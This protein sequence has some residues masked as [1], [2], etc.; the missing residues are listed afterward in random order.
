MR[1]AAKRRK[2]TLLAL[3]ADC[4]A[5]NSS[6]SALAGSDVAP[7]LTA[8]LE[9]L[10][11][12]IYQMP[13]SVRAARRL[14]LALAA[15]DSLLEAMKHVPGANSSNLRALPI[16]VGPQAS[17]HLTNVAAWPRT[18]PSRS[19][20]CHTTPSLIQNRRPDLAMRKPE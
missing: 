10:G 15:W 2:V 16:R 18:A 12:E 7:T 14:L 6:S 11:S 4:H 3:I 8:Q 1:E 9:T 20:S 13:L 19:T 5:S 17:R